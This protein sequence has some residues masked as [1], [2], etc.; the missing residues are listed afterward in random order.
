MLPNKFLHSPTNV[1]EVI[2]EAFRIAAMSTKYQSQTIVS[3]WNVH[4]TYLLSIKFHLIFMLLLWEMSNIS[5]V[6]RDRGT[7]VKDHPA[8]PE[9]LHR[10][11]IS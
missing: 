2:L 5:C 6:D 10:C 11:R 9:K 7:G 8:L 1:M 3:I 4:T